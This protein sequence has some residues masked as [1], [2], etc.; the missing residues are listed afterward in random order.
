MGKIS[1]YKAWYTTPIP[2]PNKEL[3]FK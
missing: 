2:N 1:R 3:D